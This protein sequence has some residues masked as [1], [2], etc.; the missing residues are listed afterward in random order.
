MIVEHGRSAANILA[1]ALRERGAEMAFGVPGGGPNLDVVGAMADNDI[2]FVLAHGETSACIMAS[3]YGYLT[4][5]LSAAVVTRGPGAAAAAN[6]AAQATLDRHPL[7]LITDTVPAAVAGRVPHQRIDQRAML[8]PVSKASVTL[9]DD[10]DRAALDSLLRLATTAPAGTVHIDYDAAAPSD[11]AAVAQQTLAA[12]VA[13][14]PDPEMTAADQPFGQLTGRACDLLSVARRP[15]VIVG[16]GANAF[17]DLKALL[18]TI[19]APVLTT[20]QAIGAIPTEHDLCAGLFTNGASEAALLDRADL[21]IA[22]GLDPVEPIPAPWAYKAP[23]LSMGCHPV[24]APYYPTTV[25][26]IGPLPQLVAALNID[27]RFATDHDWQPTD[28]ATYRRSTRAELEAWIDDTQP[29]ADGPG[30][31]RHRGGDGPRGDECGAS[32][33]DRTGV[34]PLE[35]VQ[36]VAAHA[37]ETLTTTVDAG[38][39]FLAIMP[40]W[41]VRRPK[42]LLISNGLAT[43]GY[44]V[45]AATAAAL[46]RPGTPVLCFVGDGGLGMTVAELETIARLELPVTVVVFNDSALSLIR[47]KQ[48]SGHGGP[49]AVSYRRTDFAAMART[50]GMTGMAAGDQAELAATME[51]IQWDR[52]NLIDVR[53]APDQYAHLITVTR[54]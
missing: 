45:P 5:T 49:A 1:S 13:T 21:I 10:V 8:A 27:D 38:A 35:V 52:P 26:L 40:M 6:G 37:P 33:S 18:E 34:T 32:A 4:G 9:G 36:T 43:M 7:A 48:R 42:Q 30:G 3:V 22:I 12:G 53:V 2:R 31:A 15:V 29:G 20:Y 24:S 17:D 19:G 54:G 44:A 25:E 47:I 50:M 14:G 46:A 28:G 11:L 41:P 16:L 39:H 51:E 23:V